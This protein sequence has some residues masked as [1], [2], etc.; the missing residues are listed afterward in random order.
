M[1]GYIVSNSLP[2]LFFFT[3]V[4]LMLAFLHHLHKPFHHSRNIMREERTFCLIQYID[5][6]VCLP[7]PNTAAKT[8]L[9]HY[10]SN[11]FFKAASHLS[12]LLPWIARPFLMTA[13]GQHFFRSASLF[14]IPLPL[15][16][17]K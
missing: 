7:P 15:K 12:T 5:C 1:P 13:P 3:T 6:H 8:R 17:I 9:F 4:M 11:Q 14:P 16:N 2:I 10:A